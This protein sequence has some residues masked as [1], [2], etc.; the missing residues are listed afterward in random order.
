MKKSQR[1]EH[2]N[3]PSCGDVCILKS[4]YNDVYVGKINSKIWVNFLSY[5]CDFC[6]E[7]FTSTEIDEVNLAEINIK[8]RNFRR[9]FKIKKIIK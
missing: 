5:Q 2:I 4:N 7:S 8:I 1:N 3:C 6:E 9:M